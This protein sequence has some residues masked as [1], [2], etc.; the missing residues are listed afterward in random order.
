MDWE[1][2]TL[3]DGRHRYSTETTSGHS[4]RVY[5]WQDGCI[6]WHVF[7]PSGEEELAEGR[8]K[9][10]EQ[11]KRAVERAINKLAPCT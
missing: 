10:T 7:D 9:D 6:S 4:A 1:I 2:E 5:E 11:A 3:D 8:S